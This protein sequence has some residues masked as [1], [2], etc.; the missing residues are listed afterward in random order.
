[1]SLSRSCIYQ[2]VPD[3]VSYIASLRSR[4]L[5]HCCPWSWRF[6]FTASVF[7]SLP[8]PASL[9]YPPLPTVL[10]CMIPYS[11]QNYPT[12]SKFLHAIPLLGTC[13]VAGIELVLDM[14]SPALAVVV[15][16]LSVLPFVTTILHHGRQCEE[17]PLPVRMQEP[18][19]IV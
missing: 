14:K 6:T 12:L 8:I 18:P 11:P 15:L 17:T 19:L 2:R 10:S 7:V 5:R 13:C 16:M 1:M 4:G 9:R 3:V